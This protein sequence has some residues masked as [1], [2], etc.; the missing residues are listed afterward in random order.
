[1]KFTKTEKQVIELVRTGLSYKEMAD[2]MRRSTH[3]INFHLKN[4]YKKT[5]T[6]S[7]GK[8]LHAVS[9]AN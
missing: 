8:M 2:T 3:T 1:M 6:H 5:A 4:I 9:A 7:K